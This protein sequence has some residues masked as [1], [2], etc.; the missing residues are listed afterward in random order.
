[1]YKTVLTGIWFIVSS[2]TSQ[3]LGIQDGL[4]ICIYWDLPVPGGKDRHLHF[5]IYHVN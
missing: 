4:G 5:L 1:M 3:V 2:N